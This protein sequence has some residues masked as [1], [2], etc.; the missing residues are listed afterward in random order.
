MVNLIDL[1]VVRGDTIQIPLTF[2]K[3]GAPQPITGWEIFFTVKEFEND[4]DTSADIVVNVT[5]HT[6]PLLGQTLILV[7]AT[8]T[9]PFA[10]TYYYD[11]RYL[12]TSGYVVTI[13]LGRITF[14]KSIS[15]RA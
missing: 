4:P 9:A 15:Q 13:M 14:W 5:F 6:N 11:I 1:D 8:A 10:G 7:P 3:N 12:D 2:N